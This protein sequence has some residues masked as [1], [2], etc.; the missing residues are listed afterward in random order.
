MRGVTHGTR[1]KFPN[2]SLRTTRNVD[3]AIVNEQSHEAEDQHIE[4]D[5]IEPEE[6]SLETP[7]EREKFYQEVRVASMHHT[8]NN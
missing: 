2:V 5:T 3:N 1:G 6:R 8:W 4:E 7:E